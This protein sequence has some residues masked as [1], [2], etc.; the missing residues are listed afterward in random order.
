M[1]TPA[2][3]DFTRLVDADIP[4]VDL[5]DKAA[6]GTTFL[7][8]KRAD[9]TGLMDPD[10]VREL[11]GKSETAPDTRETVT[12]SGSPAAIAK[13]IHEAAV[14]RAAEEVDGVAKAEM[15]QAKQNDL[16]DSDF[17][18]VEPGGKKDDEGKTTPRSLRHFPINDEAHVRNALS[19]ASQ[20][21]FGE[22]AMPKIRAAA[23]KFGIEVSKMV[24]GELDDGIDGMDPTV[25]LAE[26]DDDMDVPGD[27]NDPGSPAWEAIDA[28]TAQKWTSIAVRL[29]NALGVMAEREL[30]EAASADPDDI[31]AAWDLQDAQCALDYVID[32]L[33]GFAVDEQAEAELC[34]EAMDMVGKALAGF[35][36]APLDTIEALTTVRKAGRSLSAANEQAIRDA[37]ASLQKV[38]ASLPAAPVEKQTSGPEVAKTANEEP[39]M[40]EPTASSDVTEASGQESAMGTQEPEPVG[41]ADGE[42]PPVVVVYDQRGR[43]IGIVD[44]SDV[45]PVANAEAEPDDMNDADNSDSDDS[46]DGDDDTQTPDLTPQPADEAGTPADAVPDDSDSDVTKSTN[47]TPSEEVLK[48]IVEA[49]VEAALNEYRATQE[50]AVAKQADDRAQMA[51]LI[52][53]LK[54]RVEALEEQPAEP[55]VF[56][57]GAVPPRDQLRGM[58]RGPFNTDVMKALERRRSLYQSDDA[59]E[60]NRLANEMQAEAIARLREIQRG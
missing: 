23:K 37:V 3:D 58:D 42:K 8:A 6:N 18:Y 43:L 25:V 19:R 57:N 15:S 12:M 21:P 11:I 26:P 50:Q 13:L 24:G 48:S 49:R 20:S 14:R 36:P 52:E 33:A 28:A 4:R 7:I 40:P 22:K 38:L 56:T 10:L 45:T 59:T 51:E 27:P 31:E 2:E 5:V 16:P 17:A 39:N 46:T 30:L 44:P 60:Q 34:T 32:V 1:S 9:G 47:D 41:K 54:G 35:D 55:R 53:T 29:K